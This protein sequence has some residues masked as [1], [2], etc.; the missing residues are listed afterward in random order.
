MLYHADARVMMVLVVMMLLAV[1]MGMVR[2]TVLR[3]KMRF[4]REG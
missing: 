1:E 4:L 2:A 3:T